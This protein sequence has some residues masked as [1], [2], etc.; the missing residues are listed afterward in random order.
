M[1]LHCGTKVDDCQHTLW[2][3]PAINKHRKL[4]LMKDVDWKM[5]PKCIQLGLPMAMSKN[6]CAAFWEKE[7]QDETGNNTLHRKKCGCPIGNDNKNIALSDQY[8]LNNVFTEHEINIGNT[9]ARQAFTQLRQHEY[10][11]CTAMPASCTMIAP[12]SINVYT[13]G[14]WLFPLNSTLALVEQGCGGKTELQIE[15][16][17]K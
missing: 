15:I 14:S 9:N 5:L 12:D 16:T 10:N 11:P 3:C 2:A 7:G 1:C 17:M 4:N 8:E 13:D 6:L